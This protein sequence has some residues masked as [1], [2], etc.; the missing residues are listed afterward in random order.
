M[1][2]IFVPQT[3]FHFPPI[4]GTHNADFSFSVCESYRRDSEGQLAG[5]VVTF[6]ILAMF[7][8][9]K[10]STMLNEGHELCQGK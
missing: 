10:N 2:G 9:I 1:S 8:I 7:H 3:T 4:P 6:F 5:A